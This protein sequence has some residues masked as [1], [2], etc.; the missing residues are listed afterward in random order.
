MFELHFQLENERVII[1]NHVFS[2]VLTS[3]GWSMLPL[4]VIVSSVVC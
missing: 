4:S 3:S 1:I 2:F